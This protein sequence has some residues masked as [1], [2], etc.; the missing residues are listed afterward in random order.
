[1]LLN[2]RSIR[3]GALSYLPLDCANA[4]S[5]ERQKRQALAQSE[6]AIDRMA[7]PSPGTDPA[8]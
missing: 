2:S 6:A 5:G 7:V 1:L 8:A 4:G 3:S